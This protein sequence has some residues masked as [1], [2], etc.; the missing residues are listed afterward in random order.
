[1]QPVEPLLERLRAVDKLADTYFVDPREFIR[2][3]DAT[4][5][6]TA[7][8]NVTDICQAFDFTGSRD[9]A[10]GVAILAYPG[11]VGPVL[12]VPMFLAWVLGA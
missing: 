3:G 7:P 4:S 8:D 6:D 10:S 2:T 1:M 5:P 11:I 9:K 12:L